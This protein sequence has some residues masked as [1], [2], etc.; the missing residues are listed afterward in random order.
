[1]GFLIETTLWVD[2]TRAHAPRKV[3]ELVAPYIS[4]V[5]SYLAEPVLFEMYRSATPAER[6]DL[7]KL[8][9]T[10]PVLR[11]P[12]DIWM[13]AAELGQVCKDAKYDAGSMDLLIAAV[14]LEHDAEVVTFDDGFGRMARVSE[15]RVR[16]LAK[17]K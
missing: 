4:D 2:Y 1:M 12:E 14:A 16:L 7:A 15:L 5:D 6:L 10:I 3:K 8:F 13:R 9:E 17:P 11:T